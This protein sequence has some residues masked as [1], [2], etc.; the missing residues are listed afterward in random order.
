MSYHC[1]INTLC[2]TNPINVISESFAFDSNEFNYTES[3]FSFRDFTFETYAAN[4]D[5]VR[6][7]FT[8]ETY[9]ANEDSRR[10][11]FTFETRTMEEKYRVIENDN[12]NLI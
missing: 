6:S 9:A 1:F 10:S 11:D 8:F 4:E 3:Y 2:S 5:T 7:D 12:R